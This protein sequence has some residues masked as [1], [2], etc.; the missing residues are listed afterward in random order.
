MGEVRTAEAAVVFLSRPSIVHPGITQIVMVHSWIG[1]HDFALSHYAIHFSDG[2]IVGQSQELRTLAEG[3]LSQ[4]LPQGRQLSF[5]TSKC[6]RF[7]RAAL[8]NG[9]LL[10]SWSFLSRLPSRQLP[11][12]KLSFN[13]DFVILLVACLPI[14]CSRRD[15]LAREIQVDDLMWMRA[16]ENK[17]KTLKA[18]APRQCQAPKFKRD[19]LCEML[20]FLLLASF[21]RSL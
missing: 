4:R 2:R 11:D 15:Q 8:P 16:F 1:G 3:H 5:H 17:L 19:G 10:L 13:Q 9:A 6:I 12:S 21:G 7:L 14:G 20:L 18:L